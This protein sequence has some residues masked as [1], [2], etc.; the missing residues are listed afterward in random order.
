MGCSEYIPDFSFPSSGR[1][2]VSIACSPVLA[3]NFSNT[4]VVE[5]V[6]W[7]RLETLGDLEHFFINSTNKLNYNYI[8]PAEDNE[9]LQPSDEQLTIRLD[10]SVY[11]V[12]GYYV[13]TFQVDGQMTPVDGDSFV[14][15]CMSFFTLC[16][17]F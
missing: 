9:P 7:W 16:R 17:M 5:S 6:R 1:G 4:T 11:Q 14:V 12:V 10:A 13:T 2:S 15:Y 8:P 3:C